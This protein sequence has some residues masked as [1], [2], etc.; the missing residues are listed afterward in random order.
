MKT[1]SRKNIIYVIGMIAI[2][3]L[4]NRC[5]SLLSSELGLP[6]YMDSMGTMFI[7]VLG[8]TFPGMSVGFITNKATTPRR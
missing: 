6:L 2:G 3:V 1:I 4:L 7:A 8:G 5:L